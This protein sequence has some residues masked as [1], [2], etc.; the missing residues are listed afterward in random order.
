MSE[1]SEKSDRPDAEK[2]ALETPL[3]RPR[4][5]TLLSGLRTSFIA[6]VVVAAPLAITASIIYWFVSGPMR[7]LDLFVRNILPAGDSNIETITRAIPGFGVIVAIAG[8]V[9]L[10]AFAKNFVGRSLIR[11]GEKILDSMPVV[12]NLHRF[13]KNVFETALQKSARSFKEVGLVEYPRKGMWAIAFVVGESMG[14]IN[15]HL[16]GG[17]EPFVSVFIPTVPNPTSGFLIYLPRKDLTPL[18]MSIEDA[19]KLVFSMGLV[20][21][22]FSNPDD[23]VKKL[24]KMAEEAAQERRSLLSRFSVRKTG[25]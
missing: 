23:A 24:E 22:E 14:E 1:E 19:A 17:K 4:K 2:P 6:G 25:A 13:F 9:V 11:T 16:A 20:V 7:K 3:I 12:R 21:P 15:H 10:G 5:P 18:T 8:L